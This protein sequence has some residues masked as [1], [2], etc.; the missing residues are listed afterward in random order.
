MEDSMTEKPDWKTITY[1]V[2]GTIGL[3]TGIT[4]AYLIN[5][6]R[7]EGGDL[8]KF[9]SGEGAKIGMGI[10]NLLKTIADTGRR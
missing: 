8:I 3:L 7:Q 10:V 1:I 4:A 6:R 2:G 9:T 5:R